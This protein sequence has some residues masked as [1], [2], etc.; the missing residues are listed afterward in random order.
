[1][2]KTMMKRFITMLTLLLACSAGFA[3]ETPV[4]AWLDPQDDG[5]RLVIIPWAIASSD[6]QYRYRVRSTSEGPHGGG[7]GEQSGSL[8]LQAGQLA[9]LGQVEV[10]P[11]RPGDRFAVTLE[12]FSRGQLIS[13]DRIALPPVSPAGR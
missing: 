2:E 13:A 6:G 5:D 12:I 8:R 1:M 7:Q 4:T 3:A 11:Q 10:G 9:R